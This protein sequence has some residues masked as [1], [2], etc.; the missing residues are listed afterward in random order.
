MG[1][2][3][4]RAVLGMAGATGFYLF[5]LSAWGSIPLA[6]AAAFACCLSLG[7]ILRRRPVRR[8]V[9]ARQAGAELLRIAGLP[10]DE[11]QEALSALVRERY[12]DE[13]FS[14]FPVLKHPEA[15]M[16]AGDVLNAWK[17]NRDAAR[18]VVAATCPCEPRAALF[19]R[20]L[21]GPS[22]AIVDSRALARIL[23]SRPADSL[24]SPPR[25]RASTRIR[26]L[27]ARAASAK[28][29]PRNGLIAAM[30]LATYLATGNPYSFFCAMLVLG[31]LGVALIQRRAG[32]SLFPGAD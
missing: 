11:A 16:S 32:S 25:E 14:L 29:S 30:L 31:H 4:D 2:R 6:C 3:I 21:T 9:G 27:A 24:P 5:F 18:L 28:V 8:R 23:R 15:S 10:D 7:C 26:R 12:P 17:A 13:T 20:E 19:A 1:K 22:V